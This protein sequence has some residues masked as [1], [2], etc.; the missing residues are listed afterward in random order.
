MHIYTFTYIHSLTHAI[1]SRPQE[2]NNKKNPK[3]NRNRSAISSQAPFRF[4]R[5]LSSCCISIYLFYQGP[6]LWSLKCRYISHK[7]THTHPYTHLLLTI[8]TCVY[9]THIVVCCC[10]SFFGY[11]SFFGI[12]LR[13]ILYLYSYTRSVRL[14]GMY[15]TYLPYL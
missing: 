1:Y 9:V 15:L 2:N 8:F 7:H 10:C 6:L 13:Y 3:K 5:S 4:I 12:I 11:I 14:N